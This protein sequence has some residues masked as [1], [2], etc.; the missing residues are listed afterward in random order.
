[1]TAVRAGLDWISH[2]TFLP[3]LYCLAAPP[4]PPSRRRRPRSQR[5][6]ASNV[7]ATRSPVNAACSGPVPWTH[8]N[9]YAA[10]PG[11]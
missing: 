4:M 7:R 11:S 3:M 8:N 6:L 1:M 10:K 9:S 5:R 2:G